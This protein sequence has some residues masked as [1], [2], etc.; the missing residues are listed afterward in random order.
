MAAPTDSNVNLCNRVITRLGST[1][2]ISALSD[3]K[4]N[5]RILNANFEFLRDTVN[6]A[7]PW[8]WAIKRSTLAE[9][10]GA[11]PN[12]EFTTSFTLP[13]DFMDLVRD[14]DE[15]DGYYEDYRIEGDYYVTN[16]G[17][18][19]IEYVARIED[20]NEWHPL[21]REALVD[22]LLAECGPAIRDNL[23][24]N[25]IQAFY[26]RYE[27]KLQAAKSRDAQDGRP[28]VFVANTWVNARNQGQG[29]GNKV[30]DFY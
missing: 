4:R 29:A 11:T 19:K 13:T 5:A 27:A 28:R 15:V 25:A 30:S 14:A 18:V 6:A 10:A 9:D 8:N 24:A 20:L 16:Q 21:A 23:S 7:H 12:H 26:Q 22:L 2:T 3:D 1:D 17:T